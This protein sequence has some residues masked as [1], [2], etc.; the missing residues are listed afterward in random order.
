MNAVILIAGPSASGKSTLAK[1]LASTLNLEV[2]S[3]DDYFIPSTKVFVE[4]AGGKVRTFERPALYDGAR[5][6]KDILLSQTGAVVEGFCLFAYPEIMALP[7]SRFYLDVPFSVCLARRHVRKP[8][9]P[10]DKSFQLIGEQ[11]SATFV[12]PQQH[13]PSVRV[14]DGTRTIEALLKAV[15]STAT[16]HAA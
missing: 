13:F 12:L 8:Q 9:R 16:V 7:A 4:T 11:E 3:L 6:A 1:H 14:L 10:S 15:I 5:L 2:F